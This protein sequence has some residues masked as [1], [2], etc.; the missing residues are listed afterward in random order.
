MNYSYSD[1]EAM[2]T[3]FRFSFEQQEVPLAHQLLPRAKEIL[4]EADHRFS[5]YLPQS[6]VSLINRGELKL[7]DA[8]WELRLVAEEADLWRKKT[9]GAFDPQSPDGT[10]DPSGIVK[11]WATQSVA[12]FFEANGLCGFTINAGGDI[13]LGS[14]L[15]YPQLERVGIANAVSIAEASSDAMAT[16]D[17]AGS[18]FRAVATS[19]TAE[20]GDHIWGAELKQVTV[21]AQ[22]LITAD[23]WA[24]ALMT[25][26]SS[27]LKLAEREPAVEFMTLT[28]SGEKGYS[29]GFQKLIDVRQE[30][31]GGN[32]RA[33]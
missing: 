6:E 1:I 22:D 31:G 9:S 14:R 30:V 2:G 5:T 16:L 33:K 24:T 21:V 18:G 26:N 7:A 23:V 10:W 3:V 12:S 28:V 20:R 27:A 11:A 32:V 4:T 25:N 8:S 17:L 19:G 15:T 29:A 13:L